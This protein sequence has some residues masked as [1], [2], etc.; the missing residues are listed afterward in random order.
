MLLHMKSNLISRTSSLK[1]TKEL[2]ASPILQGLT[3][4]LSREMEMK[5]PALGPVT[6]TAYLSAKLSLGVLM[7]NR[8][9]LDMIMLQILRLLE[10]WNKAAGTGLV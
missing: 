10:S 7:S 8:P 1:K 6:M 3:A 2:Q 5:C 9:V 4:S